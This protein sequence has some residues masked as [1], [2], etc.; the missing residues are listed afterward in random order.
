MITNDFIFCSTSWP[1]A[2]TRWV[3]STFKLFH[4]LSTHTKQCTAVEKS[5]RHQEIQISTTKIMETLRIEP[6]AYWVRSTNA[7]SALCGPPFVTGRLFH[8][9][10]VDLSQKNAKSLLTFFSWAR[11]KTE[12][13]TN[14]NIWK[15]RRKQLFC[16]LCIRFFAIWIIGRKSRNDKNVFL[17]FLS[18]F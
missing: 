1:L 14:W 2:S 7:T 9:F 8:F 17:Q 5:L 4:A 16:F 13:E 10:A 18:N 15:T 6:P 12:T 11:K 3:R